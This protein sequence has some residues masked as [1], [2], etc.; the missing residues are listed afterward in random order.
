M[1]RYPY[2]AANTSLRSV[3]PQWMQAGGVQKFLEKLIDPENRKK[4]SADL[5]PFN[6]E[7]T[8]VYLCRKHPDFNGKSVAKISKM[9]RKAIDDTIFD[10]LIDEEARPMAILFIHSEED[11]RLA[12][13]HPSVIIGSDSGP[14]G[15]G[16]HPRTYGTFP[17]TIRQLVVEEKLLS[18][19]EAIRKMTCMPANRFHLWDR[20][21]IKPGMVADVV[22]FDLERIRDKSTYDDPCQ[23]S[24]GIEF[25]FV[26]GKPAIDNGVPTEAIHG[27][28]LLG[29]SH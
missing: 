11:M 23:P 20:G 9:W 17:R 14:G 21:Q 5:E 10:L 27:K 18:L 6:W 28:V 3:L 4:A 29:N 15:S 26:N 8:F 7:K 1:D 25:V 12:F 19:E 13:Q 16:S 22:L 2:T 24:E